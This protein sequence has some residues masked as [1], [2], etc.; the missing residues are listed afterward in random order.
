MVAPVSSCQEYF[1]SVSDRFIADKA[2]TVEATY[3]FELAGDGG[4]TWT[5]HVNKGEV[6]VTEG[7]VEK[8]SVTLQMKASDYV[9]LANGD[10]GGT[11]AVMTRKLKVSGNILLAR[12]M[13]DFLPPLKK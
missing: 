13:N 5:V 3:M 9:D 7:S 1:A 10:L 6:S 8:P 4:G 11:K 12:K 2:K